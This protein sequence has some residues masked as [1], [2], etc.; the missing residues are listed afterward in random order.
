MSKLTYKLEGYKKEI[1]TQETENIKLFKNYI[2]DFFNKFS[3]QNINKL[4]SITLEDLIENSLIL[5]N[6]SHVSHTMRI[7]NKYK[8]YLSSNYY[9]FTLPLVYYFNTNS[10]RIMHQNLK[11]NYQN[12]TFFHYLAII[13]ASSEISIDDILSLLVKLDDNPLI[14][15]ELSTIFSNLSYNKM[16]EAHSCYKIL[17]DINKLFLINNISPEEAQNIFNLLVKDNNRLITDIIKYLNDLF[18]EFNNKLKELEKSLKEKLKFNAKIDELITKLNKTQEIKN[19][20]EIMSLCPNDTIKNIVLDYIID[21]NSI[22]YKELISKV[23]LLETNTDNNLTNLF[24]MYNYNYALL[25]MSE[26]H[27]LYRTLK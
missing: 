7:F 14:A 21:N 1:T 11:K 12:K 13:A 6:P 15:Q 9:E 27:L 19:I 10:L 8:E 22:Y 23:T 20:D 16:E 17:T 2:Q 5:A 24:Q 25:T 4:M 26:K 18:E 3:T